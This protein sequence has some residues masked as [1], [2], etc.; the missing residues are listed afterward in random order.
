MG[1][2][3]D[4]GGMSCD[5]VGRAGGWVPI[6]TQLTA[7]RAAY[8]SERKQWTSRPWASVHALGLA[9]RTRDQSWARR[10]DLGMLW[11]SYMA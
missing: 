3:L 1:G 5:F 10:D 2:R 8:Q 9:C 7:L 11:H 4:A 6:C